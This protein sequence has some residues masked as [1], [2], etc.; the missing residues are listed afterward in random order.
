MLEK[1]DHIG[2]AVHDIE[3]SS[4]FY[5]DMLGLEAH[6]VEEVPSQKV[7]V[8]FFK[9]GET[10]IELVMPTSEDS[11]VAKFLATKGEGIH[12]VCYASSNIEEDVQSLME[13]GTRMIDESPRPGAHGA[14]VAF[15]HPKSSRG[16]LTEISQ[17]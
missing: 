12:H 8:A 3:E 14:R 15:I 4:R 16:V 6:G 5:R 1:I 9:I 11:P 17:K 7:K 2:I 13:K 10:N